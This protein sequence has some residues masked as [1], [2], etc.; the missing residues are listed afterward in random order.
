MSNNFPNL[1][2]L[3]ENILSNNPS[4]QKKSKKSK[5]SL[6]KDKKKK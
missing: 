3:I 2:R 4:P 1:K 6:K 5:K